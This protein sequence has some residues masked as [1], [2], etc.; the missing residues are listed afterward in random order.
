M[1]RESSQEFTSPIPPPPPPEHSSSLQ[2]ILDDYYEGS[3]YSSDEEYTRNSADLMLAEIDQISPSDE[4]ETDRVRMG[5]TEFPRN[6][7]TESM[8]SQEYKS[9]RANEEKLVEILKS[10]STVTT[11]S[12]QNKFPLECCAENKKKVVNHCVSKRKDVP[13]DANPQPSVKPESDPVHQR[14]GAEKKKAFLRKGARKEPS[15]MHRFNEEKQ[16]LAHR[17]VESKKDQESNQLAHL[18]RMQEQQREN[19]QKRIERRQRAREEIH[20]NKKGC[21]IQVVDQDTMTEVKQSCNRK[22][23][24]GEG[25]IESESEYEDSDSLLE[26][27]SSDEEESE[28]DEKSAKKEEVVVKRKRP[29]ASRFTKKGNKNPKRS[30][31]KP[32][33]KIIKSSKPA[34]SKE[35]QTPEMEEQWQIIKSMRRRQETTLRAAEKER[36]EVSVVYIYIYIIRVVYCNIIMSFIDY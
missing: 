1:I 4:S 32:V 2:N 34:A 5:T 18:E 9:V 30:P 25:G 36:E 14:D 22:A 7:P 11:M 27:E 20:R 19:L 13:Q 28:E 17:N 26:S 6:E 35:F 8:R 3:S 10:D 29:N 23:R 15:A 31:L 16:R 33:N 24:T 21:Q 12:N